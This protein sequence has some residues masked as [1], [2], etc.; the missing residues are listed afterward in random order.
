MLGRKYPSGIRRAGHRKCSQFPQETLLSLKN[1]GWMGGGG[2]AGA[3]SH[4]GTRL[5]FHRCWK[6][7][8]QHRYLSH[9]P[10]RSALTGGGRYNIH[11]PWGPSSRTA[12][13]NDHEVLTSVLYKCVLNEHTTWK[14]NA[15]FHSG[16]LVSVLFV[17]FLSICAPCKVNLLRGKKTTFSVSSTV[18]VTQIIFL[19]CFHFNLFCVV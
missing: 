3:A 7:Q 11:Y 14:K 15:V 6:Y 19:F 12:V 4:P 8:K 17:C 16:F 9:F 18:S 13:T 5:A 1:T 10:Q 2:W